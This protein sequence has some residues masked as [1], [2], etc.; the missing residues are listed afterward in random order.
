VIGTTQNPFRTRN[1][2]AEVLGWPYSAVTVVA[3]YIGGGFGGKDTYGPLICT[4]AALGAV[5]SGK[6]AMIAYSRTESF[7]YR[8]K[9]GEFEIRYKSGVTKDGKIKAIEVEFLIDAGA[10]ATW[11]IGFMQ[12]AAYHATGPYE[13]PNVR[14]DGIAVYTNNPPNA[15]FNGF[16][17]PQMLFAVESQMDILAEELN[18]DPVEFRLINALVPGSRTGT[19]QLLDHSV[20]IKELITKVKE[21]SNWTVKRSQKPLEQNGSKRRGIGI[22]C[23]WHGCGT[24]GFKQDWAGASVILNPDGSVE[25]STG[26]VEI[27]Q[28]TL[29][30]HAMIVAEILGIPLD[31]VRITMTDTSNVPDSGETHAQRGTFLGGTAAADAAMKLRKK[32]NAIAAEILNCREDEIRVTNGEIYNMN[33]PS[34][35]ITFKDIAYEIYMRGISPAEYGFIKARRGYPDPMTGQGDPYAAYTFGCC[36]AEVEVDMETGKV[37]VLRLFPGV[38]AGKIIQ[39]SVVKGQV[40]GCSVMGMGYALTEKVIKRRG[41]VENT[42]YSDYLIPTIKDKP[43][44]AEVVFIE[45]E[46]K[47]SAFGAKGVGEV[48]LIA[49][50]PA[51]VNAIYHAT[52][53]RFYRIPLNAEEVLLGLEREL[54]KK[55]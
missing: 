36:V 19:G 55:Q 7:A 41:R 27:G 10:Y 30:S 18:I 8:F 15:A 53:I 32:I 6:P 39:P 9:R 51:I 35:R 24:T 1:T 21:K 2:I 42:S 5:R 3:P 22:G 29:T 46:Y 17:N 25:Y 4:L 50:P 48:C 47:Y 16:G 33:D 31:S 38:A 11:T 13:V 44:I 34:A 40:C 23:S 28:G 14:V 26:I 49:T 54:E 12:R 37:K 45:D 43:E 52:G 20:G